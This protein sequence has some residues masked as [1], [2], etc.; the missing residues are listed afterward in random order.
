MIWWMIVFAVSSGVA[1][2]FYGRLTVFADGF[3]QIP[4]HSLFHLPLSQQAH[5]QMLQL[6]VIFEHME[7]TALP[8]R[9]TYIWNSNLFSVRKAYKQLSG[10]L[11][12]HPVYKWLWRLSCQNKHKVF[13]WL[14]IKDRLS[15]RELLKRKNMVLQ[16]YNCILCNGLR[17]E[18]L[19]H[20]FLECPFAIQCW[21]WLSIQVDSSLNPFQILETFRDQ[22]QVPF[23]MEIIIIMCWTIWKVRNDMVFRQL[24]PDFQ[25]AKGFFQGGNAVAP[26]ETEKKI[27]APV[28]SMDEQSYLAWSILV[29]SL[30][31]FLS[32]FVP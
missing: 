17:E 25:A 15:T 28:Q 18:S 22:L 30:L 14:L 3:S 32:F 5:G 26:S 4:I 21:A 2:D 13:F 23:A 12:L 27:L 29:L 1:S 11:V 24:N 6:Q 20:L 16:Y 31:F 7:L 10:H 19:C 9:W 8:D